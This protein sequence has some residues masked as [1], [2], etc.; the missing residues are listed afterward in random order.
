MRKLKQKL[1]FISKSIFLVYNKC[2]YSTILVQ[3]SLFI[4]VEC[5]V[6]YKFIEIFFLKRSMRL[7]VAK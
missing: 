5:I 7:F 2:N 4:D 1:L 6:N 3:L